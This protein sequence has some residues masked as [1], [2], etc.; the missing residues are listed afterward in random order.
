[1]NPLCDRPLYG[2]GAAFVLG[3][4]GLLGG[5]VA[6]A[7]ARKGSP[8][9]VT[10]NSNRAA[11]E[12]LVSGFAAGGSAHQLEASRPGDIE[13][14]IEEAVA[15]HGALHSVVY[16]GG[17]KFT[18]QYFSRMSDE[19]WETWFGSDAMACIRL[20]RTAL[21]HLRKTSGS[22]TAI[23]TYQGVRVEIQGAASAVS[24]AAV[25]RMVTVLAKEEGRYGVRANAVR[26]GWIGGART[27]AL[28]QNRNLFEAKKKQI[29][30]GRLGDPDEV[31]ETVAFLASSL[32]G[33]ITGQALTLDGGETL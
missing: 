11:A 31:G 32:A 4:S 8:V 20:A 30:L 19:T 13:R 9:A 33:F 5:A 14:A 28:M 26:C 16:A 10:Y 18:P 29:P 27:T 15:R 21:P 17:P 6:A 3:G 1:M 12:A 24:K 22:F 7:F 2:Q 25:D 23:S